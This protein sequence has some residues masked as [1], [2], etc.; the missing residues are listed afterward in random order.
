MGATVVALAALRFIFAVLPRRGCVFRCAVYA[1]VLLYITVELCRTN[2]PAIHA[3]ARAVI[4]T[5]RCLLQSDS[6]SAAA[7]V[8]SKSSGYIRTTYG[9][10]CTIDSAVEP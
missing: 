4:P 9:V 3:V 1:A 7:A 6:F 5:G 10:L 2:R 8:P